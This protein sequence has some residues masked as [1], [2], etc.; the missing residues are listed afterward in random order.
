MIR[1]G[2]ISNPVGFLLTA[3][4]KC[5]SGDTFRFFREEQGRLRELA[6]ADQTRRQAEDAE[7]RAQQ[8]KLLLDPDVP[9]DHKKLIREWLGISKQGAASPNLKPTLMK[10]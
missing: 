1:A 4:P 2:R 7:W 10:I 3:V 8:E 9:D 5:F 6:A